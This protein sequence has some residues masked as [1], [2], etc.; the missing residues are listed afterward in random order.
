MIN[1][2][3][4]WLCHPNE[5]G[6]YPDVVR[7]VDKREIYWP[8]TKELANPLHPPVEWGSGMIAPNPPAEL[9][10]NPIKT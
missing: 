1:R 2:Y 3:S 8:S 6:S 7:I 9:R 5:F 10:L 4:N